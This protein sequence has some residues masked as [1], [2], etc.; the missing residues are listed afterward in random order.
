[1]ARQI[2]MWLIPS[3]TA[4]DALFS[5]GLLLI[6]LIFHIA[7]SFIYWFTLHILALHNNY[8]L[9]KTGCNAIL[10]YLGR[11]L[12]HSGRLVAPCKQL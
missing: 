1:M 6:V 2:T 5:V 9:W 11:H 7:R 10:Q 12:V 4:I 8:K 3:Y